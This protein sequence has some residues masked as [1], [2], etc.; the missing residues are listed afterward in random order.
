VSSIVLFLFFPFIFFDTMYQH[1][2]FSPKVAKKLLPLP[3]LYFITGYDAVGYYPAPVI[4]YGD[5]RVLLS[6]LCV[7][8]SAPVPDSNKHSQSSQKTILWLG[9]APRPA[10]FSPRSRG[11]FLIPR[12]CLFSD[13]LSGILLLLLQFYCLSRVSASGPALLPQAERPA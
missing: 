9:M 12:W 3:L 11:Y 13:A 2:T 7:S 4:Y 1:N 8:L 5:H 10:I 6:D